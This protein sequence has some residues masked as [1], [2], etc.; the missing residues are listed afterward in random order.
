[1]SL[2]VTL[3]NAISGM[4]TSKTALEVISNNVANVNTEGYTR[5]IIQQTSRV[6][7]GKGA[8]VEI[9]KIA[10]NVNEGILTQYR[11]ET[12]SLE[13]ISAKQKYLTQING[14]FGRPS[15]NNS[16][17]HKM[18]DL[19][20]AFDALA[21]MPEVAASQFLAISAAE[22]VVNE[23]KR[24][25]SQVQQVRTNVSQDISAAVTEAN[26]HLD[27]IVSANQDMINIGGLGLSTAEIEDQRDRA[28]TE[29]SKIIDMRYFDNSDS[30]RTVYTQTGT[31]LVSG[32]K[33]TLSYT[34]P[35]TMNAKLDYT[36]T[37][38]V[39]YSGPGNAD[40]P[41][42]G[43]PGLFVGDIQASNDISSKIKGGRLKGLIDL[44]DN[45]LTTLQ[46]QLDELA[47][48]LQVQVNKVHN[49]GTGFPPPHSLTG[50]N[51]ITSNTDISTAT[52][53]VAIG[54]VDQNGNLIEKEMIDLTTLTNIA[55]LL[56]DGTNGINDK[57]NA[58]NLVASIDTEGHLVLTAGG[59][60]RVT[61][62]E[63]TSSITG[64]GK[65]A[66]GFSD[67]FGLNDLYQ[68]PSSPV[69]YRSD[70]ASSSSSAWVTAG[71]TLQFDDAD[72][73]STV[74]YSA[75]DSLS[76]L[77][78]K[79]SAATGITASVISADNGFRLEITKDNGGQF[80]IVET[81]TGT[82][83]AETGMRSDY[84]GIS[85]S[86][87]IRP[88]ILSNSFHLSRGTLQSDT[89]ASANQTSNTSTL[90]ALGTTGGTLDFTIDAS[91]TT[92]VTYATTDS[93][94]DVATAINS[95]ATLSKANI[96]AE[97]VISG[98]N[99]TIQISDANNDDFWIVDT[100]HAIT[101]LKVGNSQGI[102]TGNGAIAAD[103]AAAF[104]QTITFLDAPASGG[105]LPQSQTNLGTY[106]ASILSFNSVQVA[107]TEQ[108]R[109][110]QK[111]L[112][113]E[114]FTQHTS[115]AGVNM[116]EELANMI[117][118][119]QSYLAAARIITTT[120]ELFKVLTNM[121]A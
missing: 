71:G 42:G 22:N 105:G 6:V 82:F 53:I 90:G 35:A 84:R 13:Q 115:T 77:A 95:N 119:E 99:Y 34:P 74:N 110:F 49:K 120:Q 101:G 48:K 30:T 36:P 73:T 21:I 31:T 75:N 66:S 50:N 54:V 8:G 64:A 12:G 97:V 60:N 59:N 10:R 18:S 92:S 102:T 56:T 87:S 86:I 16:I 98:A 17:S 27:A 113:E 61:I 83:L 88:D 108:K 33:S 106:A 104:D 46:S 20:A 89:F 44:R 112:T 62:N 26:S 78:T 114:L 2:E 19:G 1:V 58:A 24:L 79:L 47:E 11:N 55:G 23:L 5:K 69:P 72:N 9:G 28:L 103:L 121:L 111:H 37:N 32:K 91:I 52:G 45:D 15:D 117:V 109:E 85:G 25:S 29:L 51:Y 7:E 4:T 41:I 57:F 76:T 96:T 100:G 67:F 40:Y 68:K 116:D 81:A 80:S 43:I 94:T 118:I 14:Y 63:L 65:I 70:F 38:A 93:L 107:T 3:Q 39:N